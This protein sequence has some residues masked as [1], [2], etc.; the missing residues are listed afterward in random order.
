M[1][2]HQLPTLEE[3][4]EQFRAH[5]W[6]PT[7]AGELAEIHLT[8]ELHNLSRGTAR[9][10]RA[11]GTHS[12]LPREAR[13][14]V[15]AIAQLLNATGCDVVN[16]RRDGLVMLVDEFSAIKRNMPI[17][18]WGTVL[19]RSICRPEVREQCVIYG[20]VVICPDIDFGSEH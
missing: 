20:D 18:P 11:D 4:H 12:E 10:C 14:R 3:L 13:G 9:L 2:R 6:G 15:S 16:L 19:Y 8:G 17:N 7:A 1:K 5:D